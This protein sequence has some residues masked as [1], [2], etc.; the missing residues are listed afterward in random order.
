MYR[1]PWVLLAAATVACATSGAVPRPFP[2][3]GVAPPPA[4]A[5]SEPLPAGDRDGYAISGT[6]LN[7][8][9]RPYRNGGADPDGFDCSG[10]VLYVFNQHGVRVPR[11]VAEQFRAGQEVASADVRP[12]DLLFFDTV[13]AAAHLPTHVG[14]SIGGDEFVHAPTAAGQV[15]VERMG[16]GYWGPKFVGARRLQ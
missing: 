11:T 10:L 7:L 13:S 12:G 5:P 6:A 1:F 14:I 16:S 9:G 15:R 3:P 8:R 2:A 4:V